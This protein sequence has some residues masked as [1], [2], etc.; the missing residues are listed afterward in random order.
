MGKIKHFAIF[1]AGM[2]G[3]L[4]S[5][6]HVPW[7]GWGSQT[8]PFLRAF[9]G[10]CHLCSNWVSCSAYWESQ[11]FLTLLMQGSRGTM[12][13]SPIWRCWKN[14]HHVRNLA[15]F[16]GEVM[17]GGGSRWNTKIFHGRWESERAGDKKTG[18]KADGE[19][20]G[21]EALAEA[22]GHLPQLRGSR[23]RIQLDLSWDCCLCSRDL[24]AERQQWEGRTTTIPRRWERFWFY[25]GRLDETRSKGKKKEEQR[26]Q[27]GNPMEYS[28]LAFHKFSFSEDLTSWDHWSANPSFSVL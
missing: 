25:T 10:N 11:N 17:A 21:A 13:I 1:C 20:Q 8:S 19:Q 24:M 6:W 7:G 14:W 4:F 18:N 15:C 12:F 2:E 5:S 16:P 9:L 23:E 3:A 22:L 26:A 28:C 27:S